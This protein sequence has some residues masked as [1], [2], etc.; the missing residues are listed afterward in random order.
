MDRWICHEAGHVT[1]G[2]HL[3]FVVFGIKMID[4]KPATVI[5]LDNETR[6]DEERCLFLAGGIAGE[7]CDFASYDQIACANDQD[8][9]LLLGGGPIDTYL[10][11]TLQIINLH[12]TFFDKLKRKI[13]IKTIERR[14]EMIVVRTG[15]TFGILGQVDI[16][17]IWKSRK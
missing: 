10:P 7:K 4:G 1:V 6:S 3:G 2:L 13:K 17:Q 5:G 11:M 14:M 9:I 16:E 8:R 15:K 12:R